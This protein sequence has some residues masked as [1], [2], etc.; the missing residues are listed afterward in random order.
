MVKWDGK[1]V[2]GRGE[3]NFRPP[4]FSRGGGIWYTYPW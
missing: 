3:K 2:K 4:P 1:F